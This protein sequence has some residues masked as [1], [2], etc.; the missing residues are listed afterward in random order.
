DIPVFHDD[1]HGT[2]I[3][4]LAALINALKVVGKDLADV[5]IV[6]SGV[7]AAGM[8]IIQLLMAQGAKHITAFSSRGALPPQTA[9]KDDQRQW[10]AG[11]TIS[12]VYTAWLSA[13]LAGADVF[14]GGSAGDSLTWQDIATMNDDAIVC[15]LANPTPEGNP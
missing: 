6:V 4:V 13:G 14:I 10:S 7:G 1:Q 8:A 5:R 9:A 2:A 11:L 15:A 3:V 12:L